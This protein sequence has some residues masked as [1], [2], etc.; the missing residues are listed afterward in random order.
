MTSSLTIVGTGIKSI[1]HLTIEAIAHIQQAG[2]VLYSVNEPLIAE[3]IKRNNSHAI[4]LDEITPESNRR[5]DYYAAMTTHIVNEVKRAQHV[6]VVFY[7]HPAVFAKPALDAATE[8]KSA[9]YPTYVLPGI[10]ADACLFADLGI[11]PGSHGLIAYE[12]TAMLL[13]KK[14]VDV[15]SHLILWQAGL[16]G[17]VCAID[18]HQ[19]QTGIELLKKYLQH[20]YADSHIIIAYEAALY[21]HTKPRIEPFILGNI[22]KV[23]LTSLTTLYLAPNAQANVDADMVA[24]LGL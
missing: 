2:L 14:P 7:G 12:T 22:D 23:T 18:Q 3:W 13:R 21:P 19:N 20:F 24:A 5:I 17:S 4:S 8:L 1:S 10:S 9:G 15:S 11:D 6:C 16:I